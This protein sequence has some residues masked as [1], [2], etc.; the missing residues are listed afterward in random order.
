MT[1][2]STKRVA[3]FLETESPATAEEIMAGTGLSRATVY[4]ALKEL[5][6]E[7]VDGTWPYEY[8]IVPKTDEQ[9]E[10]LPTTTLKKWND[11]VRTSPGFGSYIGELFREI[12]PD[13][14]VH[15]YVAR[16]NEAI[17]VM[18]KIRNT[19]EPHVDKPEW[20]ILAGGE[21]EE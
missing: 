10:E 4:K 8:E 2:S 11:A 18:S 12:H 1:S 16:L 3:G 21:I 7:R 13:S 15:D 9:A 17:G 6:A 20:Y 5:Q 19:L 14:D